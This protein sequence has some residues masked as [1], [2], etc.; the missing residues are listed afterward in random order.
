MADTYSVLY[1]DDETDLLELGKLFIEQGGQ[2]SVSTVESGTIALE[3]MKEHSFDAI[4]SDYQ[5]PECNG[6]RFLRHIRHDS[7]IPFILFTGKGREEVVV[8]AINSGVG[9][10]SRRA[11][12]P[13]PFSRNSA[14]RSTRPFPGGMQKRHCTVT[15]T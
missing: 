12:I 7:D 5:M 6:I 3:M 15:L 4:I 9:F 2:F 8:E 10:I 1:V 13:R 14:T 11:G